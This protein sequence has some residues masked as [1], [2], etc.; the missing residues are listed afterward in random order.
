MLIQV[1]DMDIVNQEHVAHSN[2]F[3]LP[4][5][6]LGSVYILCHEAKASITTAL[7]SRQGHLHLCEGISNRDVFLKDGKLAV[8]NTADNC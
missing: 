2:Q 6:N 8:I 3:T 1:G 7:Q 4:M 5:V